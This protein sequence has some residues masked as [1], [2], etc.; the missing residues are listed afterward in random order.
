M[1]KR[2]S[3]YWGLKK[4][5]MLNSL[6][7]AFDTPQTRSVPPLSHAMQGWGERQQTTGVPSHAGFA[8][9]GRGGSLFSQSHPYEQESP[10]Q[11]FARQLRFLRQHYTILDSDQLIVEFLAE[12]PAIYALLIDAV[13]PLQVAFGERR[14]FHI[15]LQHSDDDSFLKVA[16]QLPF[17]FDD[18]PEDALRSFDRQWWLNNCHRSGGTLVIDYEIQDAV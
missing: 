16:V 14:L 18:D 5:A 4:R 13:R 1:K 7:A 9:A 11:D 10:R 15:R 12:E 17:D 8:R 6:E 2:Y 3:E